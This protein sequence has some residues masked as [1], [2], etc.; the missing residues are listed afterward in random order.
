M[1]YSG[2]NVEFNSIVVDGSIV[3]FQIQT[4]GSSST[5]TYRDEYGKAAPPPGFQDDSVNSGNTV[6]LVRKSFIVCADY[7]A[8]TGGGTACR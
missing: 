1:I 7:T 3:A 2:G 4:Q 5:Y 8:Y 6:V